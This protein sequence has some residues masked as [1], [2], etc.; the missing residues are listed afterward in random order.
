MKKIFRTLITLKFA[1]L[2]ISL[3]RG[4][5]ESFKITLKVPESKTKEVHAFAKFLKIF[6]EV[7]ILVS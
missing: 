5:L 4:K 6:L 2:V 3:I 1:S 7:Q